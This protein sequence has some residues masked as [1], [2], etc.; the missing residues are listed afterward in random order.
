[1]LAAEGLWEA[2]REIR[3]M[4]DQL[5]SSTQAQVKTDGCGMSVA[6]DQIVVHR[7]SC[8]AQINITTSSK[9][10]KLG[11]T[12]VVRGGRKQK[13]WCDKAAELAISVR[14]SKFPEQLGTPPT[15]ISIQRIA[16]SSFLIVPVVY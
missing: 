2:A 16:K 14:R 6:R 13:F 8:M 4:C 1:M 3:S 15:T 12:C 11:P 10:K 9:L 5:S 7:R